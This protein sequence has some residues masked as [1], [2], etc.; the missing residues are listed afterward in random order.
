[1]CADRDM[2]IVAAGEAEHTMAALYALSRSGKSA[3]DVTAVYGYDFV[4]GCP[5]ILFG[6]ELQGLL[7][8]GGHDRCLS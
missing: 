7:S 6:Q 2:A 4:L 5:T 8:N 1:M 3:L